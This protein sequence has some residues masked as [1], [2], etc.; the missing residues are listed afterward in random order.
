MVNSAGQGQLD[1][2]IFAKLYEFYKLLSAYLLLF[3]KAK[4]YTLGQRIDQMTLDLLELVITAGYT[5]RDLK[6]PV[7]KKISFKLDLLKI[8]L[9]LSWETKCLDHNKYQQLTALLIEIGKMLGGW[10][11]T[12]Q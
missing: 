8:L 5:S 4:R 10:I 6:L 2:P 3:P 1:I 12:I 9:R 7:L 11:K